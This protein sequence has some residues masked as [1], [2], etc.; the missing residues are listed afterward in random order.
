MNTQAD[1]PVTA[2]RSESYFDP[3]CTIADVVAYERDELHNENEIN[4]AVLDQCGALSARNA[5]WFS[6]NRD[7]ALT[8]NEC[9]TLETYEFSAYI[10]IMS[11]GQEGDYVLMLGNERHIA[12]EAMCDDEG[13]ED[14]DGEED[15]E[16]SESTPEAPPAQEL[17]TPVLFRA[18]HQWGIIALFPCEPA[19][20]DVGECLSYQHIG[21]H[22]AAN[23]RHMLDTTARA[24]VDSSRALKAELERIGY[25]LE[26]HQE[27]SED[28]T[29][30]RRLALRA[31][32]QGA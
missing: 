29:H 7:V 6:R 21:Q 15:E 8:Y 24:S 14:S 31:L 3:R 9:G 2:Y 25:V 32:M 28:M 30:A 12:S 16:A 17:P 11:D 27:Y 10:V 13:G 5:A 26:V 22:G 18:H 19:T 23:V 20:L 4:Q 1:S